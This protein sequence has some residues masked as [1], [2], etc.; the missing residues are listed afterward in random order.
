MV[1]TASWEQLSGGLFSCVIGKSMTGSSDALFVRILSLTTILNDFGWHFTESV[2]PFC[3]PL[4][5][6][7]YLFP[8]WRFS[9]KTL[10]G[11]DFGSARHF[12]GRSADQQSSS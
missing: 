6:V 4:S 5:F 10:S 9:A 7:S 3:F 11:S 1:T 2:W 8:Q 12:S